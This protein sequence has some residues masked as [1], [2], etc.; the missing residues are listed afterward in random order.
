MR[1][2][3]T[4]HERCHK[5]H[6]GPSYHGPCPRAR[7]HGSLPSHIHRPIWIQRPV[8]AG[9][10]SRVRI[11]LRQGQATGTVRGDLHS[12]VPHAALQARRRHHLR[13]TCT[14]CCN[15]APGCRPGRRRGTASTAACVVHAATVVS[16]HRQRSLFSSRLPPLSPLSLSLTPLCCPTHR[17]GAVGAAAGAG[18]RTRSTGFGVEGHRTE[19]VDRVLHPAEKTRD[20][21][22]RQRALGELVVNNAKRTRPNCARTV[23]PR[24]S[25]AG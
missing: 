18:W 23:V 13:P 1:R 2:N 22:Q 11:S 10:S 25:Q 14:P 15:V 4:K 8:A 6:T 12:C 16:G 9:R 24:E 17:H 19:E 21:S 7:K 20:S 3:K 5:C